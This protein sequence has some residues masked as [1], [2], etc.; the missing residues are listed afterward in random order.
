MDSCKVKTLFPSE[1]NIPE[2]VDS[3]IRNH[4]E[5]S[6]FHKQ[7]INGC[8]LNPKHFTPVC[9]V[10]KENETV[11]GSITAIHIQFNGDRPSSE[12][13]SRIQVNG[14][15]LLSQEN[16]ANKEYI[17]MLLLTELIRLGAQ[18]HSI[19]EVRNTREPGTEIKTWLHAGFTLA[20][21]LNLIKSI[22]TEEQLWDELGENRRRQIRKAIA[23]QTQVRPARSTKDI[24]ALYAILH[25]L[26]AKKI[27]KVLP[28]INFFLEFF[29]KCQKQQKG[30]V[31]IAEN[32]SRIMGGIF[33]QIE[34]K[35]TMYEWYV[36]GLDKAYPH[37]HP[38]IMVTW[39]ALL[40]ASQQGIRT[41]DFMGLGKPGIPYGVRDFKL[42]FGGNVVNF[43]RYTLCV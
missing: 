10:V 25:N 39:H 5:T 26:Y 42:R 8:H 38:S 15:P 28:P 9:I 16:P 19:I 18:N 34:E 37:N 7:A 24:E 2:I 36:C 27:H 43:G 32:K 14:S 11:K 1:E 13:I 29:E 3:F 12:A 41:F 20:E 6:W 40:Y 4:P 21:H 23:H 30:I 31:L 35:N 22:G 17:L 33:C